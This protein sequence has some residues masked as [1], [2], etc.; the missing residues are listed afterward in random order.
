M[1]ATQ[2]HCT[3]CRHEQEVCMT[4]EQQAMLKLEMDDARAKFIMWHEFN[5]FSD[6]YLFDRRKSQWRHA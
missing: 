3:A 6:K 5:E 1:L 2:A 4:I